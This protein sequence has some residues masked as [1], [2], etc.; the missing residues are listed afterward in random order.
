[1]LAVSIVNQNLF[2]VVY[3]LVLAYMLLF[4]AYV[5]SGFV[6]AYN[7]LGDYSYG[8]YI[9]AFPVQ[10]TAVALFPG[11]SP[12]RLI[13]IS[14]PITVALAALSWHLV[15]KRALRLKSSLLNHSRRFVGR[16]PVIPPIQQ[17]VR[18]T[19]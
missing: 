6:R 15:E 12:L 1:M 10:Q 18:R 9:Y 19:P 7:R 2:F 5:P 4:L 3:N 16:Q 11:I 14:A 17:A 8:L 13:L